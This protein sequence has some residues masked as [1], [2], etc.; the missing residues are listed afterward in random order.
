[1]QH[2]FLRSLHF[3]ERPLHEDDAVFVTLG[4]GK[5]KQRDYFHRFALRFG[6]AGGVFGELLDA[7]PLEIARGLS[8]SAWRSPS[9]RMGMP[10]AAS[11]CIIS[12]VP[13]RGSPETIVIM[14]SLA[15][16]LQV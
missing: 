6:N 7:L 2:H 11:I 15:L 5:Q 16:F 9:E 10:P 12:E 1:M 8:T 3:P 14:S 4:Q 13:E